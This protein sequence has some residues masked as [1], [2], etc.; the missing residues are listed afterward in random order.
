MS[1]GARSGRV[2]G[3]DTSAW[4]RFG[5]ELA[6]AVESRLVA[7]LRLENAHP[8]LFVVGAPRSGTTAVYLHLLSRWEL[9]YFPNV[10]RAHPRAPTTATWLARQGGRRWDPTYAHRYGRVEGAMAPSDGWEIFHRWFPRYDHRRP[11][12]EARLHALRTTV[13]LH[14]RI[15]GAPFSNKN[16][17]N[18][19]RIAHLARLFPDALFLAVHREPVATVL[20]LLEARERHGVPPGEWWSCSPPQFL[21]RP[22]SDPVEQ[23]V[24]QTWGVE[25]FLRGSLEAL[26]AERWRRVAFESV[27]RDAGELEAWVEARYQA[28]GV[29]LR[30][31]EGRA[32]GRLRT[33]EPRD[34]RPE[35]VREIEEWLGRLEGER[36]ASGQGR[37]GAP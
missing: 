31:R 20:S 35:L 6:S 12:D 8:P 24:H 17:S 10:A 32:E 36:T 37:E 7:L 29:R 4:A 18:S 2:A 3:E 30:R 13:R 5:W 26:P 15:F 21:D 28:A 1:G 11:V 33:P 23:A 27:C 22:F 19:V 25:R 14:E 34:A 16:N 9:A